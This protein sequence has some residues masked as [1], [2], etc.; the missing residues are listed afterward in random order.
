MTYWEIFESFGNSFSISL[1]LLMT[2]AVH[3][4][5]SMTSHILS[6]CMIIELCPA[7]P[8]T[9]SSFISGWT[10]MSFHVFGAMKGSTKYS[11]VNFSLGSSCDF[12]WESL[13]W[14]GC[15]CQQLKDCQ[16]AF[17]NSHSR[18]L[19]RYKLVNLWSPLALTHVLL[20]V[21]L[22][23]NTLQVWRSAVLEC[24]WLVFLWWWMTSSFLIFMCCYTWMYISRNLF[25]H[26]HILYLLVFLRQG[27]MWS[28][29]T[30]N[31]LC[32][33]V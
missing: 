1:N 22:I 23:I 8:I 9:R 7:F 28:R 29:W 6:T 24:F 25:S 3:P 11:R 17:L 31:F 21:F 5:M 16:S 33:R 2:L 20:Y 19:Y 15:P 32:I 30:L 10:V 18:L 13:G 26:P 4:K 14:I 27:L 12:S